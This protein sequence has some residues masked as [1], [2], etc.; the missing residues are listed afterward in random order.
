L[1]RR[2]SI[3]NI[4]DDVLAWSL[5][6]DLSAELEH[7][8]SWIVEIKE[9]HGAVLPAA[10]L[11]VGRSY[12]IRE[13]NVIAMRQLNTLKELQGSHS[14]ASALERLKEISSQIS[15]ETHE[16]INSLAPDRSIRPSTSADFEAVEG[17]RWRAGDVSF[18]R[19]FG[20]LRDDGVHQC[21]ISDLAGGLLVICSG[22]PAS[23]RRMET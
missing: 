3:D 20:P 4:R 14:A 19:F 17:G 22:G 12:A 7:V 6:R 8:G 23:R 15:V 9:P 1:T 18:G 2:P 5:D 13:R 16:P 10:V 21:P 11:G